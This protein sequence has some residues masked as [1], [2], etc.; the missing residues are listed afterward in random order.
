MAKRFPKGC[1]ARYQKILNT[2]SDIQNQFVIGNKSVGYQMLLS[3]SKKEALGI[4]ARMFAISDPASSHCLSQYL[5][6]VT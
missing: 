6:E 1:A 5:L 3:L 2:A 4:L